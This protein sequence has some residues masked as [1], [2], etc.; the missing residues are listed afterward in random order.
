MSDRQQA[1]I[2]PTLTTELNH[3]TERTFNTETFLKLTGQIRRLTPKE[4]FRLMGFFKD[5]INLT[6]LSDTQKYNLAGDG[7]DI[8]LVSKIFKNLFK[9]EATNP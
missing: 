5:E 8:N 2:S 4:C 9:K 3:S 6:G 1:I 7:W